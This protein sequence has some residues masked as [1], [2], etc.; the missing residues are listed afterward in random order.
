MFVHYNLKTLRTFIKHGGFCVFLF[1]IPIVKG[2][3]NFPQFPSYK[4]PLTLEFQNEYYYSTA[5]YTTLGQYLRLPSGNYFTYHIQNYTLR[6]SPLKWLS[7]NSSLQTGYGNSLTR[8]INLQNFNLVEWNL[9]FSLLQKH[10]SFYWNID[11]KSSLPLAY[12][13][14]RGDRVIV[15][16][17]AFYGEGGL[18]FIYSVLPRSF[19]IFSHSK[20]K[21]RT[22]ELSSLLF[23][24]LGFFM[25][26]KHI[27]F[28]FS[29][30]VLFSAPFIDNYSD[31]PR[32]RWDVTD[33]VNGGS[34]KFLSV[35]PGSLSFTSWFKWKV[36][37][38]SLLIYMNADTYGA[39]YGKGFTIGGNLA[40]TLNTKSRNL[41]DFQKRQKKQNSYFLEEED[42]QNP[43]SSNP[44]LQQEINRLNH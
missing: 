10:E 26:T 25:R 27:Q 4:K 15:G 37:P 3:Q 31:S 16:D 20:L 9:G 22:N 18:W 14:P 36:H 23:N 33:R 39:R 32:V 44:E 6:Y 24:Q 5:N 2:E 28:G 42:D 43:L 11:F 13:P 35:N 34:Y 41:S 38:L 12:N 29:T 8:N 21:F 40:L 30:D 1:F 19:Y 7:L 17:G